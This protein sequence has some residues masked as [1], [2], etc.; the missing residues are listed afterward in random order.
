[1]LD[2]AE[3][4]ARIRCDRII[5]R[6]GALPPRR[7]V[8]SHPDGDAPAPK[9]GLLN[10]I[11]PADEPLT[12]QKL[13]R[14]WP[15]GSESDSHESEIPG[16]YIVGASTPAR[17]APRSGSIP[18]NSSRSSASPAHEALYSGLGSAT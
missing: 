5:A 18:S 6:I 9:P 11:P 8:E 12:Q 1:V 15:K 13:D 16:L 2:I 4:E 10:A 17:P 3:G 14:A 7:F